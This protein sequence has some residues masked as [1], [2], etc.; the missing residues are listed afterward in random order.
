MFRVEILNKEN[1]DVIYIYGQKPLLTELEENSILL[2][3]NCR[4]G[5]CGMCTVILVKGEVV[6]KKAIFPLNS[7]EILTCQ[8]KPLT[9]IIIQVP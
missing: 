5:H 4:A 3:H 9:D 1:I 2:N 7:N 8:A 6:H